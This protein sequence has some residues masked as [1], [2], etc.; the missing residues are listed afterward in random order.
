MARVTIDGKIYS[1]DMYNEI[2]QYRG[3]A[4]EVLDLSGDFIHTIT[5][6]Y[7][8]LRELE[9]IGTDIDIDAFEI[10]NGNFQLGGL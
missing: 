1:A 2:T 10:I 5:I 7:L 6:E 4:L 8:G 3:T 9:S